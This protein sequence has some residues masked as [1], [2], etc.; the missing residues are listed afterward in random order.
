M[1]LAFSKFLLSYHL[2]LTRALCCISVLSKPCL[3]RTCGTCW[4]TC[5]PRPW[6]LSEDGSSSPINS[7]PTTPSCHQ[8]LPRL[9]PLTL[10]LLCLPYFFH[11]PL[12]LKGAVFRQFLCPWNISLVSEPHG[13]AFMSGKDIFLHLRKNTMIW[14]LPPSSRYALSLKLENPFLTKLNVK[15]WCRINAKYSQITEGQKLLCCSRATL[16]NKVASSPIW[17]YNFIYKIT[18]I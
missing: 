18:K 13:L 3:I 11:N 17:L 7:P 15:S 14:V 4:V 6:R 12:E 2:V 9:W 1:F 5:T 16:S 8:S 10:P